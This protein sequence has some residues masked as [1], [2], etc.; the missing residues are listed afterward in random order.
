MPKEKYRRQRRENRRKLP[1]TQQWLSSTAVGDIAPVLK[2]LLRR[3]LS[4]LSKVKPMHDPSP[5]LPLVWMFFWKFTRAAGDPANLPVLTSPSFRRDYEQEEE[6][7]PTGKKSVLAK[8]REK[9]KKWKQTLVK[10]KPSIDESA[11]PAWGVNLE[12]DD[13]EEEAPEYLGA[14]S[15]THLKDF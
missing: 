1:Q 11:T 4:N 12:D 3:Q 8:V 14:P 7:T 6:H 15:K 13:G 5:R 2:L 10:K 9:A